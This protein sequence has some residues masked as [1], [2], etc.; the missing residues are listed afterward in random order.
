MRGVES[1]VDAVLEA[2]AEPYLLDLA[3]RLVRIPSVYRPEDPAANETAVAAL[4]AG[5]LRRLGLEIH[6]EDAAPGR[7]NVIGD[8]IGPG[9]GPLLILEGHSD[10][11]TEGDATMWSVP[12]FGGIVADGRLYG[13]GAAD[14]KGGIAAA[15]AAVRAIRD[16]GIAFP[17]R[18]RIA[19]VADEE[20]MMLGIKSFIRNGWA[21]E[22]CGA[23]ICEP[24]A[25]NVCLVQKGALRAI[26]RFRGR[27]AHGAMPKEGVNPILGSAAFIGQLER[28]ER[29]YIARHGRHPLLGEPCVTPTVVRAGDLAQ[30]NVIHA[31]AIVGVD[32]RAIPGQ[33][34]AQIRR[35]LAAAVAAAASTVPGCAG[36]VEVI[37]E[38]PCTETPGD[39]AIVEA[40]ERACRRVQGRAPRRQGVPGATDGTFLHAWGKVPIVTIGPGDVTIPHQIDEFVRV[41]D[42][43]E[44]SRIFAAAACYCLGGAA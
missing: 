9:V 34:H 30:L 22:A 5:E 19:V 35:D 1:A 16:A 7:P 23:I 12:P 8:W 39:A 40:V 26:A 32:V 20:G 6:L 42:L 44:A 17:G 36:D 27:M 29:E 38:R 2:V 33:D 41:A 37:E 3:C 24:E 21:R 25:N 10:V 15:I 4:V 28:L 31:E 11:V 14:M 43:V 13:R 18:I